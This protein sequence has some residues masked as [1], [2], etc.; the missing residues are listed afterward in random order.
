MTV[1]YNQITDSD[2]A[3]AYIVEYNYRTQGKINCIHNAAFNTLIV[4]G[5][6]MPLAMLLSV[7]LK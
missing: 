6:V 1:D 3:Y 5:I 7:I 2:I 4:A